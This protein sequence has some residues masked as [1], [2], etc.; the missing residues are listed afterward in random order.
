MQ[1][2]NVISLFIFAVVGN[3]LQSTCENS[4]IKIYYLQR[5]NFYSSGYRADFCSLFSGCLNCSVSFFKLFIK[6]S[7]CPLRQVKK[8]CVMSDWDQKQNS[9]QRQ[10][11][12]H[13]SPTRNLK[14]L[15]Q[16]LSRET[17]R[18]YILLEQVH[19][20]KDMA[21]HNKQTN[22]PGYITLYTG[23]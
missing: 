7:V 15:H 5:N 16:D 19:R 10:V 20:V 14:Q 22:L 13:P 2:F 17:H 1:T 8:N 12:P 6:L 9:K 11:Y 3:I 18:P 23:A 4:Q 21:C